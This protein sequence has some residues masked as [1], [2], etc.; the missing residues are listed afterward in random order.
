MNAGLRAAAEA[1]VAPEADKSNTVNAG[2]DAMP[3]TDIRAR[4]LA[5]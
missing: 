4:R 5:Q 2:L 3:E 1:N